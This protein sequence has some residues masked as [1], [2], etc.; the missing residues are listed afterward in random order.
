MTFTA[1]DAAGGSA[2][3]E[4]ALQAGEGAPLLE[5]LRNAA[6]GSSEAVCSPGALATAGGGWFGSGGTQVRVNGAPVAVVAASPT[7]VTFV[8]P[9]AA[10][11][12]TLQVEVETAQGRSAVLSTLMRD[13]ALGIFQVGI[14]GIAPAALPRN[15]RQEG[16][17]A[18]PGD[19][20]QITV[21]GIAADTD[22]GLVT[23]QLGDLP[24][25]AEWVRPLEGAA[26]IVQIGVALPGAMPV[27][28]S[29]PITVQRRLPDGRVTSSQTVAAAFEAV[30]Q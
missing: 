30:R 19:Q 15:P 14:L 11:G 7:A 1:S 27:G 6:S 20:L 23:V 8:C 21:T 4:V 17:P 5:G 29:V 24:V 28:D 25:R 2:S 22:P 26:G 3:A 10:V 13:S 18:Q 9:D 16:K 12:T